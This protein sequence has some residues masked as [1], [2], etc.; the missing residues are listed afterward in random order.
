MPIKLST[1]ITFLD[2]TLKPIYTQAKLFEWKNAIPGNFFQ[3]LLSKS[4][5]NY[6]K[7]SFARSLVMI[8]MIIFFIRYFLFE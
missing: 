8:S 4:T 1:R 7:M 5:R 6:I 3:P 2:I